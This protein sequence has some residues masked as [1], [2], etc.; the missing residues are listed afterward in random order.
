MTKVLVTGGTGFI[1]SHLVKAL[2]QQGKEVIV[3]SDFAEHGLENLVALGINLSNMTLRCTDLT[4]YS[5]ALRAVDGASSVFHLAARIGNLKYLHGTELAELAALQ[6]NLLIDTNI[7]RACLVRE[8]EKLI[9]ASSCA[10]YPIHR[11]FSSGVV[12]SES[13]LALKTMNFLDGAISNVKDNTSD[14]GYG[15][16][17]DPDGGYGWAKLV[18]ETQLSWM[19]T[20]HIGI[21]RIFN[22]YGENEP[23]GEKAHVVADLIRKAILYPKVEFTVWGDG[24][25]TRDLLYV[26]DC[27]DALLRLEAVLS[28]PASSM[29]SHSITVN[30]G[31]D[32]P[33]PVGELATKIVQ[34]S[35][36][37]IPKKYD[38]SKPVG[39]RSRTA[40]IDRAKELLGWRP[41]V[42]LEE[43]LSRV[44]RWVEV[45][46]SEGE[47]LG[48]N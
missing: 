34:L 39:P 20:I 15:K 24:T 23:L 42:H 2:V 46:L 28:T 18:G 4:D 19:R 30:I 9:Y 10:V 7:F 27:V 48:G 36:K 5:Q 17:I 32:V 37:K 16:L 14:I 35:G 45:K 3:A 21:A 6:S 41:K 26:S 11:Q 8:I 22:V 25:Q 13:D 44:Y 33:M 40:N 12:F 29:N 47:T 31:S 1:G 43:G 38:L